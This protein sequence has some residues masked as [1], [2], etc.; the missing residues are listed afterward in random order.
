M[1]L[2][3]RLFL[4]LAIVFAAGAHAANRVTVYAAASL[5]DS[6]EEIAATYS[7][8]TNIQVVF[9][10]ASSSTLARQIEAGAPAD[11]VAL[12]SADWADY[13][14][15]RDLVLPA[16][17]VA[18]IGN[19]LVLVAPPDSS[20]TLSD[21][22]THAEILA[23]LGPEGRLAVG[24]PAHVPA[25]IYARQSLE[26]LGLWD[27]VSPHLAYANDVRAALALVARGEVPLGIVY[28]SDLGAAPGV[29][30]VRTLPE[31]SHAPI[32]YAFA[33]VTGGDKVKSMDFLE[34]LSGPEG[35]AVFAR[36]GFKVN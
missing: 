8:K 7:K 11:I 31:S 4:C 29:R 12:A 17:R 23:I 25:G 15:E 18:P 9:S 32:A 3:P 22:P 36:H 27:A 10:F 14:A 26:S 33:A 24:D 19:T 5:T 35:L 30:T 16:S 21:P 2:L 28:A 34:Y 13:L 1:H 20:A 6:L